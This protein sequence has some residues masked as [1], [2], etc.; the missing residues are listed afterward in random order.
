MK[1]KLLII[2]T[3]NNFHFIKGIA[4]NLTDTF[5]VEMLGINQDVLMAGGLREQINSADIIWF[6]WADGFNMDLLMLGNTLYDKKVIL[7]IQRYELFT[8]RTLELLTRLA[9]SGDYK[10]IDKLIFVSKIVR[11]IGISKF[12]WMAENS[13]VIPNLFDHTKFPFVKKD[14]GYNLLFL[15]RI[16]Y[17]KNLP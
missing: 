2:A 4:E 14:K 13:V 6:E 7:R 17:V 1:K 10:K 12:P 3:A 15:G 11:Q 16:S 5:D 8:P 9:Y